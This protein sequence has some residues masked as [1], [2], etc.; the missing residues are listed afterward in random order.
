[1]IEQEDNP[2]F[3]RRFFRDAIVLM[4]IGAVTAMGIVL[5]LYYGA[6]YGF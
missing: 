1:M 4:L 6:K 2:S 5:T 3:A